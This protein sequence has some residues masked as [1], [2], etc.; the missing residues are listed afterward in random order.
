MRWTRLAVCAFLL[1]APAPL[2]AQTAADTVGIARAVARA[3]AA[4]IMPRR[5]EWSAVLILDPGSRMASVTRF[6]S[7]MVREMAALPAFQG[8]LR[9]LT[10]V[11]EIRTR[12]M[13]VWKYPPEELTSLPGVVVISYVCSPSA[14][15]GYPGRGDWIWDMSQS[16]YI[17]KK[18]EAGWEVAAVMNFDAAHGS[19]PAKGTRRRR[20]R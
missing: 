16:Q 7:L 1:V 6:D 2:H 14:T 15:P 11:I 12:G 5:G 20:G 13:E 8:P 3:V 9:D 19:C 17:V 18:G 10:R 4:E